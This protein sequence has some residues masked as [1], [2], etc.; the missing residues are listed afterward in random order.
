MRL[1]HVKHFARSLKRPLGELTSSNIPIVANLILKGATEANC[2]LTVM[3]V[4]IVLEMSIMSL[5]T[6]FRNGNCKFLFDIAA[7][8]SGKSTTGVRLNRLKRLAR[9]AN[10]A[11]NEASEE[12]RHDETQG[13]YTYV[14]SANA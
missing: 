8:V 11:P 12:N 14:L 10:S 4:C 13:A 2:K 9:T 6:N 5:V 1:I 3:L 7:S